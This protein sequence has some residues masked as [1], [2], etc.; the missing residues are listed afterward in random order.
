M[1][2]GESQ[3]KFLRVGTVV[4]FLITLTLVLFFVYGYQFDS[5]SKQIV[6]KSVILLDGDV[7]DFS[8]TLD[9]K[10]QVPSQNEFRLIPGSYILGLSQEGFFPWQKEV[11]IGDDELVRL[12]RPWLIPNK[13]LETSTEILRKGDTS[14]KDFNLVFNTESHIFGVDTEKKTFTVH[15]FKRG[16]DDEKATFILKSPF[17]S[18]KIN[19]LAYVN[20]QL[21]LLGEDSVLWS[22]DEKNIPTKKS[23]VRDIYEFNDSLFSINNNGALEQLYKSELGD[24]AFENTVKIAAPYEL[25]KIS[26]VQIGKSNLLFTLLAEEKSNNKNTKILSSIVLTDLNGDMLFSDFGNSSLIDKDDSFQFIQDGELVLMDLKKKTYKHYVAAPVF[27]HASLVR[28]IGD[29]FWLLII[30]ATNSLSACD[31]WGESCIVLK[32]LDAPFLVNKKDGFTWLSSFQ[33]K[34]L[35]FNFDPLNKARTGLSGII[36]TIIEPANSL[37]SSVTSPSIFVEPK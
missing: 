2:E 37:T 22:I 26:D 1:I 34:Q 15:V 8:Q 5:S 33:N 16:E 20:N 4:V 23:V 10:P 14:K 29:T 9:S 17:N 7:S 32:T 19:R 27:D 35:S 11:Y 31:Q 21:F 36:N 18:K 6:K 30:N 25:E 13:N 28:R 24:I 12:G 3:A